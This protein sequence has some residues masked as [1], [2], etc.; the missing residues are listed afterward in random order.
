MID[1]G[2]WAIGTDGIGG[3]QQ[4]YNALAQPDPAPDGPT[5]AHLPDFKRHLLTSLVLSR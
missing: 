3:P 5:Y 4:A 2:G 1:L